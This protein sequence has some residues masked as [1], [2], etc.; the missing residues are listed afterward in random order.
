MLEHP[1]LR[2][3]S[4]DPQGMGWWVVYTRHQHEKSVAE[5]LAAKGVE[6]FLPIY[7]TV[8]RWKDRKKTLALPLFPCYLFVRETND[9]RLL[10]LTTP[11]VHMLLTRGNGLAVVPHEEVKAIQRAL[12]DPSHVEPYPF[13]KYGERM[14][15]VRGPLEGI[16]GILIRKKNLY[17]LIL[18]VQM[19]AQSAAVE[20]DA[21]DVEP[22]S[23][24]ANVSLQLSGL[25][26]GQTYQA[27]RI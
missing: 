6:V 3:D 15:V 1:T 7:E 9:G 25:N 13:L 21:S 5:M 2:T 10:A 19:L 26:T 22:V 4:L 27:N 18:S 23:P 16:E 8:H 17:R 11:G 20:V 12:M 14:R 24:R